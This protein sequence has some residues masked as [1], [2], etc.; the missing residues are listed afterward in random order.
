MWPAPLLY[1]VPGMI[2]GKIPATKDEYVLLID[3]RTPSV[4][5]DGCAIL[6]PF[7]EIDTWYVDISVTINTCTAVLAVYIPERMLAFNGPLS[8]CE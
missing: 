7:W 2:P 6:R 1:F 3:K 5:L 8:Y 4:N